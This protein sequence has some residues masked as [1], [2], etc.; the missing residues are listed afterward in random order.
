MLKPSKMFRRASWFV[1]LLATLT[2]AQ[3]AKAVVNYGNF[4]GPNV[5][6]LNVTEDPTKVPGPTPVSLFGA[7]TLNG[8]T[9]DFNPAGFKAESSNGGFAFTD[10][11]LTTT[12][13]TTNANEYITQLWISEFGSYS[14]L[15]G[16]P[17]GTKAGVSI[18]SI[19]AKVTHINNVPVGG[20]GIILP[21]TIT[22]TNGGLA[23]STTAFGGIQFS[24]T[25]GNLIGQPWS[26]NVSFNLAAV[27]GATKIDLVLDNA[28]FATSEQGSFAFIDKKD[29]QIF[30][31]V[32][33]EPG[34]ILLGLA[35]GLGLVL[36]GRKAMKKQ[37]A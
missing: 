13:M 37:V 26:A 20:G 35:G 9:L 3:A 7:P 29:F 5:M 6:Y 32:V 27:P 16:T 2:V 28:L 22:Y 34:T 36:M 4:V 31:T 33:P 14:L 8:N 1:A 12:L 24:S 19:Q 17:A 23:P 18:D 15:G 11:L 30:N 21:K 10:S 25:G